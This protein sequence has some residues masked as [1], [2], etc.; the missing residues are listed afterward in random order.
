VFV[1][2]FSNST[3]GSIRGK[4]GGDIRNPV[5]KQDIFLGEV[6]LSHAT[7]PHRQVGIEDIFLASFVQAWLAVLLTA[8]SAAV[9]V[10][11]GQAVLL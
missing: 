1:Q 8:K 4:R 9:S 7:A 6:N 3:H 5:G 2:V 11:W 10:K